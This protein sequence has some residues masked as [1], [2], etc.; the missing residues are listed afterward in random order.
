[1][2]D[3]KDFKKD[4]AVRGTER[5][6]LQRHRNDW[7]V[8]FCRHLI[9]LVRYSKLKKVDP[10]MTF[11]L[12]DP[13]G[14][15]MRDQAGQPIG[16]KLDE[17]IAETKNLLRVSREHI[18]AIDTLLDKESEDKLDEYL[19]GTEPYQKPSEIIKPGIEIKIPPGAIKKPQ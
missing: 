8:A 3:D 12:L 7:M 18:E 15:P 1:M 19:G 11:N 17:Q 2:W 13:L 6:T 4:E 10:N 14:Q 9:D 5:S 16:K